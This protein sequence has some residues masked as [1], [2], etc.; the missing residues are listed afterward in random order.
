MITVC[1]SSYSQ[2]IDFVDTVF[3]KRLNSLN[4]QLDL[5]YNEIIEQQIKQMVY[6]ESDKV[7]K[8]LGYFFQEKPYIDSLLKIADLPTEL[9]YLPLALTQMGM[10][11]STQFHSAGIWQLPYFIAV[12]YGLIIDEHIDERYD[13]RKA[14][15]AAI[16]YLQKLSENYI[17]LWDII[18][19]YANSAS[20]LHAAKLRTKSN[21]DIWNLYFYGNLP[22]KEV[23]PDVITWVY[24]ANFYQSHHIKLEYPVTDNNKTIY[25]Q[26]KIPTDIFISE[27]ELNKVIFLQCNPILRGTLIPSYCDINIPEEKLLLFSLKESTLYAIADSL[28]NKINSDTLITSP[29]PANTQIKPVY[30]T[31]KS[32]DVL[33]KIAQKNNTTVAQLKKWN[34]LKSDNI[35]IGQ[36]LIVRQSSTSTIN[37]TSIPPAKTSTS[38]TTSAIKNNSNETIHVVQSGDVLIQIANKYNV[39]VAQLKEWNNLKDDNI[40]IG[41]KLNIRSTTT[42]PKPATNTSTSS[43]AK[44]TTYTVKSGDTLSKIARTYNVSVEE[45]KKWNNLKSDRLDIGQKLTIN[46]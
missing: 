33:G 22:D 38:Q 16:A 44:K 40:Q 43:A 4:L 9:Q 26:Q 46:R 19:A 23:I 18:I 20:A 39:T 37:Q 28:I 3:T 45:I 36:R 17:N 11:K 12:S 15:P 24:L 30:Y 2:N 7:G 1:F 10:D 34:N 35:S 8:S 25:L 29:K 31:V 42:S 5:H 27:L 6:V 14:T 21:N 41:Q 13:I 32:G